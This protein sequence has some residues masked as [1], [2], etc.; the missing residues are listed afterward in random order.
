[1]NRFRLI[2]FSSIPFIM[3]VTVENANA[4]FDPGT[5]SILLQII[6]AGIIGIYYKFRAKCHNLFK[7]IF[8]SFRKKRLTF[9][10][11]GRQRGGQ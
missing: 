6:I 2:G 4:Y 3:I 8:Q 11:R 1:M 7:N 5:G 9:D 10:F